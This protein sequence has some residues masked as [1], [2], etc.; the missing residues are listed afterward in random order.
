MRTARLV[1]LASGLSIS[2]ILV[3][4]GGG[5]GGGANSGGSNPP[6]QAAPSALSYA[7]PQVLA[8]GS[9]VNVTPTVTGSVT[10][11]SISPQVPAGLTFSASTGVLSGSPLA[12][13]AEQSFNV[14]A[15]NNSGSTSFQLR[16]RVTNA[17]PKDLSYSISSSYPVGVSLNLPPTVTGQPLSYAV[18]PPLP[19]GLGL[20]SVTGVIS[21]TATQGTGETVYTVTATNDGGSTTAGLRFRIQEIAPTSVSYSTTSLNLRVGILLQPLR[22]TV[23][24][25]NLTWTVTPALPAGISVSAAGTLEGLPRESRSA[26]NYTIRAT[27]SE[28]STSTT[29]NITTTSSMLPPVATTYTTFNNEVVNLYAWQGRNVA[30]LSRNPN[31][32]PGVMEL[33]IAALDRGWDFYYYATNR[34]PALA[35]LYNGRTTIADVANTCGAGCGYLGATGIEVQNA[36][37]D[38]TYNSA[39]RNGAFGSFLFYEFGRNFWFYDGEVGYKAPVD[40][41]PVVTGYAVLMQWWSMRYAGVEIDGDSCFATSDQARAHFEG[42]VD[43]YVNSTTPLTW[44]NTL[45]INRGVAPSGCAVDA[46]PLFASFL[47]RVEHDYGDGN[48]ARRLWQEVDARPTATTTAQAID[49][50]VLAASAASNKNLTRLFDAIWHW[51]VTNGAWSQAQVLY[52]NP[53]GPEPAPPAPLPPESRQMRVFSDGERLYTSV[54]VCTVGQNRQCE[55]V[56][57]ILVDSGSSGLRLFRPTN[58]ALEPLHTNQYELDHFVPLPGPAVPGPDVYMCARFANSSHFGPL[59]IAVVELL[60]PQTSLSGLTIAIQVPGTPR[61]GTGGCGTITPESS[62]FN[63][64]LGIRGKENCAGDGCYLTCEVDECRVAIPDTDIASPTMFY[65]AD[66]N[67][68]GLGWMLSLPANP[69]AGTTVEGVLTVGL[70]WPMPSNIVMLEYPLTG[71]VNGNT[72]AVGLADTGAP[73]NGLPR[74]AFN[75]SIPECSGLYCPSTSTAAEVLLTDH[76][77]ISHWLTIRVDRARADGKVRPTSSGIALG[78]PFYFGKT[79]YW[80]HEYGI[81]EPPQIGFVVNQ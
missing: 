69:P 9:A 25:T 4:C 27:N 77:G 81:L 46:P 42:L 20:D 61:S 70:P 47:M 36:Y 30:V 71:Q 62:G 49:N 5:G 44:D 11:Y 54:K 37:F 60:E 8:V 15:S 21:G 65:G 55:T 17:A 75:V 68:A 41:S 18:S 16:I 29:V 19:G 22:P 73:T 34:V 32:N 79:V 57:R 3:A 23:T 2:L 74:S 24:G 45:G 35:K 63:G 76:R 7:N 14:V 40:A 13:A 52:G 28:G 26:A 58:L 38:L 50:L 53:V 12:P 33:W 31:L 10:S 72:Y 56:D 1:K 51:P 6:P 48:F 78:L 80:K 59:K 39:L 67:Y 66:A 64:I 43:V